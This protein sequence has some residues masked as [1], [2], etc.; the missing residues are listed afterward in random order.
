MTDPTVGVPPPDLRDASERDAT[1]LV[2]PLPDFV[3]EF[4]P[5]TFAQP[6]GPSLRTLLF[7]CQ[8]N[9][10][11]GVAWS[12][13]IVREVRTAE[14]LG[15]AAAVSFTWNP[16][17]A[18]LVVHRV[19]VIRGDTTRDVADRAS[20][21]LMR[22]EHQLERQ[23][24]DG[25][26]TAHLQIPDVRVGDRI[27]TWCTQYGEHAILTRAFRASFVFGWSEPVARTVVRVRHARDRQFATDVLP[28]PDP[29]VSFQEN[30]SDDGM[31]VRTWI[32]DH[33]APYRYD[34]ATPPDFVQHLRLRV[35]ETMTWS[36]AAERH[37][38]LYDVP[39]E[40]PAELQG[41]VSDLAANHDSPETRAVAALRL[42]QREIRYVAVH[43]GEG[44]FQPRPP[45]EVWRQ[46]FGDC[47]DVSRL[48]CTLMQ[49]LGLDAVPALVNSK[50]G[51]LLADSPPG[52]AVFDHCIT[53]LT[54]P[55]RTVWLDATQPEQGG[56]LD[57]LTTLF[58]VHALPLVPDADLV[59]LPDVDAVTDVVDVEETFDFGPS[60]YAACELTVRTQYRAW[61]ADNL[62]SHLRLE[63]ADAVFENW[64][65]HY[66]RHYE[67]AT[68]LAPPTLEDDLDR[69]ALTV[70]E[71]YKLP[72]TW[73]ITDDLAVFVTHDDTFA[74]DLGVKATADRRQ[75]FWLGRPRRLHRITRMLTP[76]TIIAA[77]DDVVD[78]PGLRGR[79]RLRSEGKILIHEVDYAIVSCSVSAADV[80][81]FRDGYARLIGGCSVKLHPT[82]SDGDFAPNANFLADWRERF[83][84]TNWD[85]V[86]W[87]VASV[88][89]LRLAFVFFS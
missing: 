74:S 16:S 53:R 22:R 6:D 1:F 42:V 80:S 40:L 11:D 50:S 20:F 89:A 4:D 60:V 5:G 38:P 88:I 65:R 63:G 77:W 21:S 26:L 71:R 68:S 36:E 51:S 52:A 85:V 41:V 37:R 59:A 54:L 15:R 84:R 10:A 78:V 32:G 9:L 43:L 87:F 76:V 44:G 3:V 56:D 45:D 13:R 62:R 69:N 18:R 82:L 12:T 24:I 61:R 55:D 48:L 70:V 46:R 75:P 73:T 35:A 81:R 19:L 2:R 28:A 34:P 31:V 86:F 17:W 67:G 72:K 83:H 29:A 57:H 79:T 30:S 49:H 8:L 27:E 47:K 33:V 58:L 23:I 64:R 14:G 25:S 7:D 66:E 39:K